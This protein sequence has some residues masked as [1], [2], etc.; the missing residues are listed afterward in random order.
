MG[1]KVSIGHQIEVPVH[2][3]IRDGGKLSEF[4][5]HITGKRLSTQEV[6]EKIKGEGDQADV[7]VAEFLSQNITGWRDQKLVVD[8]ESGT[9][10]D[11]S[12][13][14]LAAM[15]GVAGVAGVIYLAYL[16][17]LVAS[18]GAEGRRKN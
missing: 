1:F 11:F 12:Q 7:T 18:D 15:L 8:E 17:E 10:A 5:F 13:D 4:K 6:Q 14:A 16:K 2:L 9:P 3:K